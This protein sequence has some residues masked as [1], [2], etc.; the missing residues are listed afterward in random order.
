MRVPKRGRDRSASWIT[1]GVERGFAPAIRD[2]GGRLAQAGAV[3]IERSGLDR[4]QAVVRD[5]AI[6]RVSI[7]RH[8]VGLTAH[9]TC[10]ASRREGADCAHMWAAM[11]AADGGGAERTPP[12][13]VRLAA[14]QS[15]LAPGPR[16]GRWAPER[17]IVYVLRPDAPP[18][19][20]LSLEVAWRRRKRNGEWSKPARADRVDANALPDATD[21]RLVA[22][23][24]GGQRWGVYGERALSR[25]LA[26]ELVPRLCASGRC[27]IQRL[28][29]VSRVLAVATWEDEPWLF[30]I[31][32]ADDGDGAWRLEGVFRRGDARLPADSPDAATRAG[33]LIRG[34]RVAPYLNRGADAWVAALADGPLVVP[35]RE[36]P[37]ALRT[38]VSLGDPPELGLPAELWLEEVAPP[39]KP[40]LRV[41]APEGSG[42]RLAAELVFDYDGLRVPHEEP[43]RVLLQ[44]SPRRLVL[45]SE[46]DERAAEARLA[47]LGFV[48]V[49]AR[50]WPI[51]SDRL[52]LAPRRLPGVVPP[53][54]AEGWHV[55][56]E[57]QL[58]R[59]PGR[60]RFGVTSSIDWFDLQA[61]VSFGPVSASLPS[62]LQA[63][64]RRRTI[65]ELGDG[66]FGVLPEEWLEKYGLFAEAG[67]VHGDSLRFRPAQ[68]A[69]L[70]AL[71]AAQPHASAD[72]AF[73]RIRRELR[74]F[75]RVEP[76][77][78]PP[79]FEGALRDYQKEG[80]GWLGFLQR[81][82]LGGCLADDMGL[83]KT[84]Q[85]LALL[86]SRAAPRR[87]PAPGTWPGSIVVV[88]RSLL[89]NWRQEAER[90][91]PRLRVV[92]HAGPNRAREAAGLAGWDLVLTTYGTVRRDAAFLAE[93][94]FDYVIL[95][96]AQAIKNA[97]TDSAKA[98]RL[99]RGRHRLA[100]SG[101][102]VEN[103][104]GELW[105]LFEFL[106]PG[107]LGASR[108]LGR[109]SGDTEAA[110]QA[111][112]VLARAL[113]PFILRRTKEQ[114]AR[115]LPPRS[116]QT[117]GCPL[118]TAQRRTYDELRDHY[119]DRV[120]RSV[121]RQGL[122]GS[123]FLILEALLRLRQAACHPALIDP[124]RSGQPSAKLDA[125]F[126]MLDE[127]REGGHRALVFSQFT[128][129][130]GL[131]RSR[132]DE[133]GVP[134]EYL[135]GQTVDR[136]AR[137]ERFQSDPDC[138][139]FLVSLKAGGV[140]L[141]LTAAEYVFLLDPWWNPAVE[142]QAIDRAHRIGQTRPVF[143][144]RLVAP[145]TVEDRILELQKS[146]R[147]LA[148]AIV[149][150]DNRLIGSLGAD[151]LR[152]LLS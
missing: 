127:L 66:T 8:P 129:L 99:L 39:P 106:N 147:E 77:E 63:I 9:C 59:R 41:K 62:I 69:L 110:G 105:S 2:L 84:V 33:L 51:R 132:L 6:R 73:E 68:A 121:G 80:L 32:A 54:V 55:E 26:L 42:E 107:M 97:D 36:A 116:E 91:T 131:V 98:V 118:G 95:D 75:R 21:R 81:L 137:V 119:R 87:E 28:P 100:L 83:G 144:Y 74:A 30:R 40:L 58:Y 111:R 61:E 140:G 17:Q 136:Q 88:P 57:G 45:R 13:L 14:I 72:E 134:Y 35:R 123:A 151:D 20:L 56:A 44:S 38:L 11:L 139:F 128:R 109:L 7:E 34:D 122:G 85:V 23:L 43:R 19:E 150:E 46:E 103:H 70:D 96:E 16:P 104:L 148:E 64:A 120:M 1:P 130:L 10:P 37:E 112:A 4:L 133:Q 53:L 48:R 78:E 117:I 90:F 135:D 145:D 142:M 76:A 102:P 24:D 12:W 22:L 141:N 52:E 125:L 65:V 86:A 15:L 138:P 94:E 50:G 115:D 93:A 31:E 108:L 113:R 152:L 82:R 143:A 92:E 79:G 29:G 18:R 114:V 149:T 49:A 146:K 60:M 25:E 5:T 3:T 89:F 67:E 27:L 124:S 71:L 47:E 126:P 101:T